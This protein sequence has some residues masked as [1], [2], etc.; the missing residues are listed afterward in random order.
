L[1]AGMP[2]V[3]P[4]E[5]SERCGREL[6]E[7]AKGMAVVST[8]DLRHQDADVITFWTGTPK[9]GYADHFQRWRFDT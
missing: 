1:D 6:R 5:M 2:T 7:P 8:G 3:A 4:A 9:F